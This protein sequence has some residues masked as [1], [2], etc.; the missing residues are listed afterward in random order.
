MGW[1]TRTSKNVECTSESQA[2]VGPSI[3]NRGGD[4]QVA[5]D[6]EDPEKLITIRKVIRT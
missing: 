1:G 5:N 4:R 2:L 6:I 3:S